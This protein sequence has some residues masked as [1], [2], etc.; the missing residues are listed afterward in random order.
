VYSRPQTDDTFY[1]ADGERDTVADCGDGP[2][3]VY[4]DEGLDEVDL[5]G[6]TCENLIPR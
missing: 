2:D 5:R 3:T 4:F 6:G 1:V